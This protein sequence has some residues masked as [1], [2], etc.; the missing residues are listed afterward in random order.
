MNI[1]K[2]RFLDLSPKVIIISI[3]TKIDVFYQGFFVYHW[4]DIVTAVD[5]VSYP[6]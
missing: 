4:G 6:A 5:L 1:L 3:Q 2:R